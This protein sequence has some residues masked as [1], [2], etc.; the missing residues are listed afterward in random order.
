[1][2]DGLRTSQLNQKRMEVRDVSLIIQDMELKT[3]NKYNFRFLI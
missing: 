2:I 3:W 1:M